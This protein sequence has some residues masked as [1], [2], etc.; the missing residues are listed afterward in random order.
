MIGKFHTGF[1]AGGGSEENCCFTEN[2]SGIS[3]YGGYAVTVLPAYMNSGLSGRDPAYP[4]YHNNYLGYEVEIFGDSVTPVS[5]TQLSGGDGTLSLIG[6]DGK[7][8]TAA[9]TASYSG[10]SGAQSG[11]LEPVNSNTDWVSVSTGI[12]YGRAFYGINSSGELYVGGGNSDGQLGIG[13]TSNILNGLQKVTTLSGDH[14]T[15]VS[16]C[17][18]AAVAIHDGGLYFAGNNTDYQTAQ[19]TRSG[20]TISWTRPYNLDTGATDTKTDWVYCH[21]GDRG[22]F[23]IDSDGALWAAGD[24]PFGRLGTGDTSDKTG[25]T[26]VVASG[27]AKAYL[28]RSLG[29]YIDTSGNLY[30]SGYG[31]KGGLPVGSSGTTSSFVSTHAGTWSELYLGCVSKSGSTAVIGKRTNGDIYYWGAQDSAVGTQTFNKWMPDPSLDITYNTQ[32]TG[33]QLWTNPPTSFG[34]ITPYNTGGITFLTYY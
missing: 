27:V 25:I 16:A 17:Y 10:K 30:M 5:F 20:D 4:E 13:N 1:A 23:A 12:Y 29:Y 15:M 22:V 14:W 2:T 7:W 31:Y 3:F 28:E 33:P 9:D 32:N 6:S 8:Y 19:N 11:R 24:N 34:G 18:Y 21:M 26:K